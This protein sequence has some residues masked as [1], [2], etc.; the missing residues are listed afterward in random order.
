MSRAH[1]VA[2]AAF[3]ALA[4]FHTWPIARAP[5][6][7][8]LNHNADAQLNAW[9][10]AWIAHTLPRDPVHLFDGNIFAPEPAT[11][12]YDDLSAA[13]YF[14]M[15]NTD[16]DRIVNGSQP[17]TGY[18]APDYRKVKE[19]EVRQAL[20]W[21]YPYDAANEAAGNLRQMIEAGS[22]VM[23]KTLDATCG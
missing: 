5:G 10:I 21:A 17:C 23:K 20:A 3:L 14:E 22:A 19:I 2:L 13:A 6:R 4:A 18:L 1:A 9:I 8:S 15:K 7:E 11:L 12:T 16:A